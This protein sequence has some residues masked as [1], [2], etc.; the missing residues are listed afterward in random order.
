MPDWS[1]KQHITLVRSDSN[2]YVPK[3]LQCVNCIPSQLHLCICDVDSCRSSSH[4]FSSQLCTSGPARRTNTPATHRDTFISTWT[5]VDRSGRSW[6]TATWQVT[7]KQAPP[8]QHSMSC[9]IKAYTTVRPHSPDTLSA[10]LNLFTCP[11][12]HLQYCQHLTSIP[13]TSRHL[14][15]SDFADFLFQHR[16]RLFMPVSCYTIN[17]N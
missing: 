12:A 15:L 4:Y 17:C 14:C 1:K 11:T 2:A 3:I 7:H 13:T 5:E 10:R 6:S 9:V 8:Y 16:L